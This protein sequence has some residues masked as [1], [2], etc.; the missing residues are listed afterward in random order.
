[1]GKRK[2]DGDNSKVILIYL[3]NGLDLQDELVRKTVSDKLFSEIVDISN[4][5]TDPMVIEY[6]KGGVEEDD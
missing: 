3:E 5:Y 2:L 6:F 4:N 1:M